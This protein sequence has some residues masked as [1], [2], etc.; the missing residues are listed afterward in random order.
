MAG[1]CISKNVNRLA[2]KKLDVLCLNQNVYGMCAS[3][4][5]LTHF[6]MTCMHDQGRTGESVPGASTTASA[7]VM[8][9]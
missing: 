3:G 1:G 8:I 6:A 9:L 7:F 2:T 4:Q 5:Y